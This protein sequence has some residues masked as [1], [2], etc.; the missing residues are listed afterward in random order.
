MQKSIE[1]DPLKASMNTWHL[2]VVLLIMDV[3][4]H[5]TAN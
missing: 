5:D 2:I 3:A 1:Y 4:Y